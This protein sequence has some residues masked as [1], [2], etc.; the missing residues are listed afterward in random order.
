MFHLARTSTP[1]RES[2]RI[3]RIV[4][5]WRRL[6]CEELC[7]RLSY[8]C[9]GS[10]AFASNG[11]LHLGRRCFNNFNLVVCGNKQGNTAHG[12]D[13]NCGLYVGLQEDALNGDSLWFVQFDEVC[14]A[15]PQRR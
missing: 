2:Q 8:G 5:S 11:A 9:L 6:Q 14:D 3:G 4:W 12:T 1:E 15:I 13:G 7:N 10:T